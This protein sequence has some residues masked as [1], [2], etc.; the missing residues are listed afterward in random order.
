[1]TIMRYGGAT[2]RQ[3]ELR[4]EKEE[5]EREERRRALKAKLKEKRAISRGAVDTQEIEEKAKDNAMMAGG[6]Q[7]DKA[8]AKPPNPYPG[9]VSDLTKDLKVYGTDRK[10]GTKGAFKAAEARG[11][12]AA[13]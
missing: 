7:A 3:E 6:G 12:T 9:V 11:A 5:R 8:D 10:C 1:M 2:F 4:R 13:P